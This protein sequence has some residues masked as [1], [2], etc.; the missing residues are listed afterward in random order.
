MVEKREISPWVYCIQLRQ[1]VPSMSACNRS[2]SESDQ[3]VRGRLIVSYQISLNFLIFFKKKEKHISLDLNA[4]ALKRQ[5]DTTFT[6]PEFAK[7]GAKSQA[8]LE[9]AS[10]R[11]SREGVEIATVHESTCVLGDTPSTRSLSL[12]VAAFGGFT[13]KLKPSSLPRGYLVQDAAGP[14][15]PRVTGLLA[16]GP[17]AI[18]YYP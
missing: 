18:I 15:Q 13:K 16:S 11:S 3:V 8:K 17:H 5:Y 1:A 6:W 10:S 2:I 7:F 14:P 12:A 4:C 9:D